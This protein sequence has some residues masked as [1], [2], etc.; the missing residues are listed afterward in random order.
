MPTEP[1]IKRV[2]AFVDGQNLYRSA[3]TA[4]GY[5]YPNYDVQA[6]ARSVCA[7]QGWQ[8]DQVRF[9]TGTAQNP[10]PNVMS[11]HFSFQLS[12]FQLSPC[13][14]PLGAHHAV[15]GTRLR[16]GSSDDQSAMDQ[17]A[18]TANRRLRPRR[19]GQ[20]AQSGR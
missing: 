3:K 10:K 17:E 5:H 8:F 15:R 20:P 16:S 13:E 11:A 14:L 9:Y 6:L 2:V 12:E 18:P 7:A 4:F 1:T 19:A